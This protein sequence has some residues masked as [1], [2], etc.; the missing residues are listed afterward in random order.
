[1]H[2]IEL[3]AAGR[4]FL[5]HARLALTQAEA[6]AEA[7]RRAAQ[8]TKPTFAIGFQTGHEMN[9]L[10]RAMHV[11]RDELKNIEVTVLSDYSPDLAEAL[12]RSRLS[13]GCSMAPSSSVRPRAVL[14]RWL[15]SGSRQC[16]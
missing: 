11:L 9:W 3:T 1:V 16:G 10:P 6:A 7:A 5:D 12:A 14:I 2:G 15:R 8:R 4:A 13:S